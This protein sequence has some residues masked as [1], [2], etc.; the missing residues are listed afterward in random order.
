MSTI[1]QTRG[2]HA[3]LPLEVYYIGGD[4]DN[5]KFFVG[6]PDVTGK[7]SCLGSNNKCLIADYDTAVY[8]AGNYPSCC[9]GVGRRLQQYAHQQMLPTDLIQCV[10]NTMD[11]Q[12]CGNLTEDWTR[13]RWVAPWHIYNT[14]GFLQS[15]S[16][17]WP[18]TRPTLDEG[19]AK[20]TDFY[21]KP[22]KDRPGYVHIIEGSYSYGRKVSS[23]CRY[24]V[25][26][27]AQTSQSSWDSALT[28]G[29]RALLLCCQHP[30]LV[31]VWSLSS[32]R[33]CYVAPLHSWLW[34]QVAGTAGS[35]GA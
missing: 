3:G 9:D 18:F 27:M 10:T 32:P 30:S 14:Y 7:V 33:L 13:L 8:A 22:V 26:G 25:P 15:G 34:E 29:R 20:V 6:R 31:C 19:D 23:Y 21:L 35:E 2:A 28:Q 16:S 4:D 1:P 17:E 5:E 24:T 12:D 11:A